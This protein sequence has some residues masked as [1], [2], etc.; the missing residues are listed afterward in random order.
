MGMSAA[1]ALRRW[2]SG[3]EGGGCLDIPSF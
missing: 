2:I 3:V 1:A